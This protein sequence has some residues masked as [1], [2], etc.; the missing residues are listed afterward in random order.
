MKVFKKIL[1]GILALFAL[2]IVILYI[3]D[4]DYLLK[5]VRTIY[6]KGHSTAFLEDYKSFDNA[7]VEAAAETIPWPK[8]KDYN[9]VTPTKKLKNTHKDAGTTAYVIIKNDS[10]WYESYY[11]GFD[12]NS[13]SNSFSM[14]K[15]FISGLLGKAI[16]DGHIKSL[17][18]PLSDFYPQYEGTKTTV[19][20]LASMASGL[21]WD[22]AY[23]SPFSI[24]TKAYFYDDLEKM[25]LELGIVEEPAK[26]FKYLSGSTQLLAMVIEKASNR[27]IPEYFSEAFWKPLG[28]KNDA[29]WQLDSE[30]HNMVKAYC[31]FASNAL[32]F[33]RFGKLYKDHGRFNEKQILDS[34]FVAKSINPRFE[35]APYGYGFWLGQSQ[36]KD[37][38]AMRGHLG[39]YV[40]VFPQENVM[41][42]RLGHSKGDVDGIETYPENFIIYIEEAFKMLN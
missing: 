4:Y 12:E 37:F 32:D 2:L 28:A 42:V 34:A 1:G 11:D 33:A 3:F 5:A 9:V 10:I 14:A 19:G 38:F 30:E 21:D 17:D 7:P 23:Y 26:E 41:V 18:Q 25:M 20:D 36:G 39:Q 31:C 35:G 27:K 24:T 13:K 40:I 6:L 8:H 15:S 29:L 16:M 22:E